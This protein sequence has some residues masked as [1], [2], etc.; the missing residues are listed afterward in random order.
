MQLEDTTAMVFPS[1]IFEGPKFEG[2]SKVV[3]LPT[4]THVVIE[5]T[6]TA[7]S[8]A[9][10]PRTVGVM[11]M[12]SLSIQLPTMSQMDCME[13]VTRTSRLE[14][15]TD[16]RIEEI[17]L[18]ALTLEKTARS[19]QDRLI[20][21]AEHA[22]AE[23]AAVAASQETLRRDLLSWEDEAYRKFVLLLG[24]KLK[25]KSTEAIPEPSPPVKEPVGTKREMPFGN[26]RTKTA[27][28]EAPTSSRSSSPA[29]SSGAPVPDR[30]DPHSPV[31]VA[32]SPKIETDAV[33]GH[34]DVKLEGHVPA[35]SHTTAELLALGGLDATSTPAASLPLL[36]KSPRPQSG[37]RVKSIAMFSDD[38]CDADVEGP[39]AS[40]GAAGGADT[41]GTKQESAAL[42]E[43]QARERA[44][45]LFD[46]ILF[47]EDVEDPPARPS[48]SEFD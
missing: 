1:G 17:L 48:I 43:T 8:D 12:P 44:S 32:K 19:E 26:K 33:Y 16:D 35:T 6:E 37:K 38:E 40:A 28:L 31:Q 9:P 11:T 25:G 21:D 10:P 18:A 23:T 24:E 29:A 20:E 46:S 34:A 47:D 14:K 39:S 41:R 3:G 15:A 42:R 22:E 36:A 5:R 7:A 30:A 13:E 45:T 27:K 4:S 2:A